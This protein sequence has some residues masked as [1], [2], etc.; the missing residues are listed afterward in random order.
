MDKHYYK[1]AG[2]TFAVS[3]DLPILGHTFDPKFKAFEVTAPGEDTVFLH[4]HFHRLNMNTTA[5]G[6]KVYEKPPWNIY[7][8]KDHFT[9]VWTSFHANTHDLKRGAVFSK[10]HTNGVIYNDDS[11]LKKYHA[12]HMNALT[13]FPTDQILLARLLADRNGCILHSAGMIMDGNGLIFA[14]HSG[15]GKST[16]SLIMKNRATLLCDDRNIIRKQDGDFKVY[17]TWSHGDVKAVCSDSANL[18]AI[19]FLKQAQDNTLV[20][21]HDEKVILQNLLA[22]LVKSFVCGQW[23]NKTLDVIT[24]I[25][26]QVPCYELRFDKRGKVGSLLEDKFGD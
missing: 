22:C 21:M 1:T 7:E 8:G 9:Y 20:R 23:W 6:K 2:I 5:P 19:C 25:A 26:G 4:H 24:E 12:G 18:A 3:S 14:G 10:D 11:S 17:G 16:L 15:A 13:L